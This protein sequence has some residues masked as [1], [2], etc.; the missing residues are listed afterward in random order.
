MLAF[1]IVLIM[2]LGTALTNAF[3]QQ[4]AVGEVRVL[5]KDNSDGAFSQG[6]KTFVKEAKTSG[7][8]FKKV[9]SDMDEK[10][11]I[12]QGNYDAYL[13]I[14]N[15]GIKLYQMDKNSMK[16][17]II[18]GMLTALQTGTMPQRRSSKLLLSKRAPCS[19]THRATII[20]RR[21]R[22]AQTESPAPWII[23]R[24]P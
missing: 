11:E 13:E 16:N 9:L 20:S 23:M 15:S 12:K 7:V 24:L 14:E 10:Q 2:I 1:P 8:H 21:R 22:S 17:S 4:A 18:Q 19:G 6:F 5:Y 3:D